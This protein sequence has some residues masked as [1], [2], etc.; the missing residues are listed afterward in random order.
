MMIIYLCMV[1]KSGSEGAM[2]KISPFPTEVY[3]ITQVDLAWISQHTN[4]F[5]A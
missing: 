1:A 4:A 5:C 3:L 2:A